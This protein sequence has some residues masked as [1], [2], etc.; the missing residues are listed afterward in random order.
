MKETSSETTTLEQ[1]VERMGVFF[2]KR[3]VPPVGARIIGYLLFSDPPRRSFYEI[4]EFTKASKSS[5]SNSLNIM[6]E[7]GIVSYVTLSGD[8]KRYFQI[9]PYNWINLIKIRIQFMS[10][11]RV[12]LQQAIE[13]HKSN[14]QKIYEGLVKVEEL[15]A[16]I[17]S[18]L[19]RI[20]ADWEEKFKEKS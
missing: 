4:V 2:E 15:Y 1:Q 20:I 17:E 6:L 18:E 9:A 7:K 3:G 14:D 16:L 12:F 8:R 5:V 11:V 10:E 13:V 19:P